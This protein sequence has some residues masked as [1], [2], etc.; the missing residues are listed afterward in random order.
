MTFVAAQIDIAI[1][2]FSAVPTTAIARMVKRQTE[3]TKVSGS[4]PNLPQICSM[5]EIPNHRLEFASQA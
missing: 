3:D 2:A 4:F 5:S 1:A